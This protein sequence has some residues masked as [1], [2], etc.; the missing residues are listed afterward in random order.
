MSSESDEEQSPDSNDDSEVS[1]SE[2]LSQ[3]SK[4]EM[5][6][7]WHQEPGEDCSGLDAAELCNEE[8]QY[9]GLQSFDPGDESNTHANQYQRQL[10][11]NL[12]GCEECA[13]ELEGWAGGPGPI[14][15]DGFC[16]QYLF[17]LA[18]FMTTL[19]LRN[20][21]TEDMRAQRCRGLPDD[22]GQPGRCSHLWHSGLPPRSLLTV[23]SYTSFIGSDACIE[24]VLSN[25]E[26]TAYQRG[27]EEGRSETASSA[28]TLLSSSSASSS[29]ATLSSGASSSL[30]SKRSRSDGGS[31]AGGSSTNSARSLTHDAARARNVA[32]LTAIEEVFPELCS[33]H[34][35]FNCGGRAPEHKKNGLTRCDRADCVMPHEEPDCFLAWAKDNILP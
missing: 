24:N 10:M 6:Q 30:S 14:T 2:V 9:V 33:R 18:T 15:G 8:G 1:N 25:V 23:M 32:N 5:A 34:L 20:G 17:G 3:V 4:E 11:C 12:I 22:E 31:T 19:D 28:P 35:Y 7:D 27:L 29:A 21:E 26:S 13:V 16:P